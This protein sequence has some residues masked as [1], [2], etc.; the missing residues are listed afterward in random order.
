LMFLVRMLHRA[1]QEAM[2]S[3]LHEI[4]RE[5]A[6]MPISSGQEAMDARGPPV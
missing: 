6:R 5:F 3:Q 1:A 4:T 2:R